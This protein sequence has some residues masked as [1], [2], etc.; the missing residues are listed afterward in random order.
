MYASANYLT[1]KYLNGENCTLILSNLCKTCLEP[2]SH[3]SARIKRFG[4]RGHRSDRDRLGKLRT[5][6]KQVQDITANT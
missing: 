4:S 1:R 3:Y 6:T 2:R 5:G